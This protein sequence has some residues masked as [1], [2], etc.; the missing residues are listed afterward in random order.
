MDLLL[1]P[2]LGLTAAHAVINMLYYIS[3]AHAATVHTFESLVNS[4]FQQDEHAKPTTGVVDYLRDEG[5]H[6]AFVKH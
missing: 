3:F 6:T 5:Q 2:H 1:V 4:E